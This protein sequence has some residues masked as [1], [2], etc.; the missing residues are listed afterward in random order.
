MVDRED[1]DHS[2]D[3]NDNTPQVNPSQEEACYDVLNNYD[4]DIDKDVSSLS[5]VDLDGDKFD[6][7]KINM[8]DCSEPIEH[9]QEPPIILL[10]P[11]PIQKQSNLRRVLLFL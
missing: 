6:T 9:I 5:Y 7:P 4:E 2:E 3:C 11:K 10:R 8:E 1:F